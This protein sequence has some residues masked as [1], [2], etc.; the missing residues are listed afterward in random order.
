MNILVTGATGFIGSYLTKAL[1][2]KSECNVYCLTRN[3]LKAGWLKNL[4]AV[5]VKGDISEVKSLSGLYEHDIDVVFHCAA[6]VEENN[7]EILRKVNVEGTRNICEFAVNRKIKRFIYLSSV[8]VVSAN[9]NAL[10]TEDLPYKA[11]NNYGISKIEAEKIALGYRQKGLRV[12]ILRPPMVYGE[13]EPHMM[14]KILFLLKRRMLPLVSKGNCVFHLVYVENVVAAMLYSLECDELLEGTYFVADKEVLTTREVFSCF[15]QGIKAKSPFSLPG[16]LEH[17][18]LKLPV[19]GKKFKFFTKDR[20]YSNERIFKTGF[21][22][23]YKAKE[24]LTK[25]ARILYYG[26]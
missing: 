1:L 20:A 26:S 16:W 24:A 25:S 3:P 10:L 11:T 13:S 7:L 23:P 6:S 2:K 21:L 12:V 22:P 17:L 15:C 14:K 18:L 19:A 5:I 9:D 8:A 4:G